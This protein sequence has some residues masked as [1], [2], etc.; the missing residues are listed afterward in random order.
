MRTFFAANY[1]LTVSFS[2]WA[3]AQICKAVIHFYKTEKFKMERLFGAGG[4]PSSHSATVCSM[5]MALAKKEGL[6]SSVFAVGFVIAVIV[7]YDAMGVR[8]SAGEHAKLLNKILD[9]WWDDENKPEKEGK[10]QEYVGH[11]PLEVLSGA[12]LGILISML[13]PVF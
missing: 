9:G 13:I 8:R 10:L 12:L 4:M 7:M 1:I 5:L 6:Q 3:F 2:S 11:T